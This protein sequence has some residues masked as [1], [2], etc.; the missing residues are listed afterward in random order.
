MYW[1]GLK[2]QNERGYEYAHP[3]FITRK[4]GATAGK[5]L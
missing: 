2:I 4:L 5:R 3:Y 1:I